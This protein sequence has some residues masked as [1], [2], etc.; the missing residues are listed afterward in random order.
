MMTM[1]EVTVPLEAIW[2]FYSRDGVFVDHRRCA[3]AQEAERY[4]RER[5]LIPIRPKLY[6]V[7]W[8]DIEE[9]EVAAM[10]AAS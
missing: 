2:L 5:D 9:D 7:S 4:A 3:N 1:P 8:G 6:A 10:V